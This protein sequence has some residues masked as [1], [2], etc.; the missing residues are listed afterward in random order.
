MIWKARNKWVFEQSTK[1][2]SIIAVFEDLHRIGAGVII[3]NERGL[4]IA[5]MSQKGRPVMENFVAELKAAVQT[6]RFAHDVGI[7]R[8]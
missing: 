1:Q 7:Q 6:I 2:P 3:R 5:A 4:L 8:A